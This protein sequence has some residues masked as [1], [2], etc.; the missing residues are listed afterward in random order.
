MGGLEKQAEAAQKRVLDGLYALEKRIAK[1]DGKASSSG[2]EAKV[3]AAQE[4]LL[5]GLRALDQRISKLDG[6]STADL[7]KAT[8]L[9]GNVLSKAKKLDSRVSKLEGGKS[10]GSQGATDYPEFLQM[11]TAC[12]KISGYVH[13]TGAKGTGYYLENAKKANIKNIMKALSKKYDN[14]ILRAKDM[15]SSPSSTK[16]ES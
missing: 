7:E 16:S 12:G 5:T 6:K 3:K 2:L 10:S 14:M 13:R 11:E 8:Q 9:Y 1:L 4:K 15:L